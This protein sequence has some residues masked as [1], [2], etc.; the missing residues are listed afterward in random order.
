MLQRLPE[1]VQIRMVFVIIL[2]H[3]GMDDQFFYR[4]LV[5][6]LQDPLKLFRFIFPQPGLNGYLS[7]G[8]AVDLVQKTVQFLRQGQK[9]DP[10]F[11]LTTV[12][13]GQP[14]FRFTSSYPYSRSFS[15]VCKK[16]SASL[17]MI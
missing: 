5:I 7:F 2:L 6:D 9:S 4:I 10:P 16:P 15:S 17:D 11:F 1:R 13:E 14:R 12:L 8:P 3:P